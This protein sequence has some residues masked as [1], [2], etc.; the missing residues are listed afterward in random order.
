MKDERIHI[1]VTAVDVCQ[2]L[3]Q[4]LMIL[5]VMLPDVDD[6]SRSRPS[7]YFL[8]WNICRQI[9]FAKNQQKMS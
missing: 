7:V 6:Y 1:V 4:N 9:D 2:K 8:V 5:D 3:F